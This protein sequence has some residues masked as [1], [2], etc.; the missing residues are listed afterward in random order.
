MPGRVRWGAAAAMAVAV[1]LVLWA[2][3]VPPAH[4]QFFGM[5]EGQE[6]QIGR[7]VETEVANKPGFVN[8]PG[9][10]RYVAGIGL[11]LARVSERPALPWTYHIVRD[12]SVNAFAAPGGF[13]FVDQG[14]LRFVKSEDELGFV[15]GHETT[16]V[17]HRHAV[18]LAQ[19][20]MELQFGAVLLTQFVFGGNLA[21]YQ[22]SQLARGLIDAKYSR[23]KEFEADHY[24]VIYARKAG[25]NPVASLSFFQRLQALDKSQPGLTNAFENH[26]DT[27]D[28]IK[29]LRAQL[30]ALG[31][32][33]A[34]PADSPLPPPWGPAAPGA[35]SATTAAPLVTPVR[36]VASDR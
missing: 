13:L 25:F 11:R 22:I 26:P 32:Q 12:K 8:D 16:H 30:R 4:A 28:R 33:V 23:D 29:A 35:A 10:T 34:A 21:A 2:P 14:L 7:Q 6:I 24:G 19:R 3:P 15:L 17:A 18:D 20:D 36:P 31:Y 5:S 1:T 9:L 27:P